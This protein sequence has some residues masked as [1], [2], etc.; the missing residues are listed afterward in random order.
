MKNDTL[1]CSGCKGYRTTPV[2]WSNKYRGPR[3]L[4]RAPATADGLPLPGCNKGAR[5]IYIYRAVVK[6]LLIKYNIECGVR[7]SFSFLIK[8]KP[9]DGYVKFPFCR[10]TLSSLRCD[11][12]RAEWSR[13]IWLC[14]TL[15]LTIQPYRSP[16]LGAVRETIALRWGPWSISIKSGERKKKKKIKKRRQVIGDSPWYRTNSLPS[17]GGLSPSIWQK[18][19]KRVH[20]LRAEWTGRMKQTPPKSFW[21]S[22]LAFL[23]FIFFLYN[24]VLTQYK[25]SPSRKKSYDRDGGW[26]NR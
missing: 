15:W 18:E 2:D 23:L 16:L 5:Y 26:R 13:S 7:E 3:N 21:F 17:M 22:F 11:R 8:K 10:R 6:Q 24:L 20:T 1:Y 4:A 9:T 19:G 25:P 14:T 12:N